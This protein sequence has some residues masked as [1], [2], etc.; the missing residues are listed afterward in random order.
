MIKK[1]LVIFFLLVLSGCDARQLDELVFRE[2]LRFNLKDACAK[3]N[4]ACRVAVKEQTQGCMDKS[5]WRKFLNDKDN[6]EESNRF[7]KAFYACLV[8][9]EGKPFFEPR[10]E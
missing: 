1:L 6:K 5:D 10:L 9:A 8:D 3:E 7:K 4:E 2:V